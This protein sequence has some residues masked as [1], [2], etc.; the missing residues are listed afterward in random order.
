MAPVANKM[1]L[2]GYN[3]VYTTLKSPAQDQLLS[4]VRPD[5][6]SFFSTD[7]LPEADQLTPFYFLED[8]Q[9]VSE[10]FSDTQRLRTADRLRQLFSHYVYG[11]APEIPEVQVEKISEKILLLTE[12]VRAEVTELKLHLVL[13]HQAK[14]VIRLILF[15]PVG[16]E[17]MKTP[18]ILASNHCG[19]H[20]LVKPGLIEKINPVFE[21]EKCREPDFL[22][23]HTDQFWSVD[24]LIERGYSFASFHDAEV[25]PDDERLFRTALMSHYTEPRL[26]GKNGWGA[27]A[28]WAWG[29][30]VAARALVQADFATQGQISVFGHSRRGKAALWAAAN[31]LNFSQVL[32]HQSG[33]LGTALTRNHLLVSREEYKKKSTF[34]FFPRIGTQQESLAANYFLFPHW[35]TPAL[36]DFH[37]QVERLP[38]D[39]HL[40][41]SLLAP[42]VVIDSQGLQD[43][44]SN[45]ESALHSVQ[46]GLR[47]YEYLSPQRDEKALTAL[48]LRLDEKHLMTRRYWEEILS[49]LPR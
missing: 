35:F 49:L 33:T 40:L 16:S 41:F 17:Q 34:E 19:N 44:W 27:V 10:N 25:A 8:L 4:S 30:R 15:R 24:L 12:T 18:L 2:T 11:Y 26:T 23:T 14:G 37:N 46:L 22:K 45:F 28:A 32:A 31:D 39:Q 36:K 47:Y 3:L 7:Q 9:L 6:I 21:N 1:P 43:R 48:Q 38:V 42:R 20:L 13:P 29:L 5:Y